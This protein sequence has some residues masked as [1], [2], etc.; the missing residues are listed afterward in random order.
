MSNTMINAG[1]V[2]D[3]ANKMRKFAQS[4]PPNED[5]RAVIAEADEVFHRKMMESERHGIYYMKA[6]ELLESRKL[7]EATNLAQP[8]LREAPEKIAQLKKVLDQKFN[9]NAPQT[10]KDGDFVQNSDKY[11]KS[12]HLDLK[13][14]GKAIETIENN[15]KNVLN[16]ISYK[17]LSD[18]DV[19]H[20]E[21][22]QRLFKTLFVVLYGEKEEMFNWEEFH[23]QA[24]D[25]DKGQDFQRR[26]ASFDVKNISP[27][28]VQRFEKIKSD[29]AFQDWVI[30]DKK[31]ELLLDI[32]EYI[33]YIPPL[34]DQHREYRELERQVKDIENDARGRKIRFEAEKLAQQLNQDSQTDLHNLEVF[35]KD[36]KARI[37]EIQRVGTRGPTGERP[38]EI[39]TNALKGV[40]VPIPNQLYQ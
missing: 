16:S 2:E 23:K 17:K 18:L 13:E 11:V 28:V 20:V 26:L 22:L 8:V 3:Y 4:A 19:P 33:D 5:T 1:K 29:K 7:E 38:P 32:C 9:E 31:G 21:P 40:T 6:D 37:D 30:T 15:M 34:A 27:E 36:F 25:V 35:L 10:K 12:K 14:K 24:F 39:V